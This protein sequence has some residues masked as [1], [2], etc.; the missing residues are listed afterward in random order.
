MNAAS[1]PNLPK[2]DKDHSY[3]RSAGAKP[4]DTKSDS[5]SYCAPKEL[6]VF[7]NRATRPSKVS[8]NIATIMEMAARCIVTIN[9]GNNGIKTSKQSKS[10][11]NA[12][13]QID[14]SFGC[15]FFSHN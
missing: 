9:R 8:H 11:N 5:E 12:W 1:Q 15:Y 2:S 13:K 10:S 3:T 6:W 7:V 14:T 4:N